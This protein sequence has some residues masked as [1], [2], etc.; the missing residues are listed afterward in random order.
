[1]LTNALAYR[2]LDNS[3]FDELLG[4]ETAEGAE[5]HLFCGKVS[6]SMMMI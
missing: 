6:Q 1:M 4:P 5:W 2:S 3:Q